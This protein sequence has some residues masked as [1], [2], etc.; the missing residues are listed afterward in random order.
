[1]EESTKTKQAV[2]FVRVNHHGV[3]DS[4]AA[5]R[6]IHEQRISGHELAERVNATVV[7]EYIERGG[8]VELGQRGTLLTMLGDLILHKDIDYVIA[9]DISRISR[10]IEDV[11]TVR[12]IIGDNGAW[13]VTTKSVEFLPEEALNREIEQAANE[14]MKRFA[15]D[16]PDAFG[17][18]LSKV[19]QIVETYIGRQGTIAI[20]RSR[21][22]RKVSAKK[23]GR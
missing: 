16:V 20:Q 22:K 7:R 4:D 5:E 3:G 6:L 13:L 9:Q 12:H 1:M 21:Q 11:F 15:P 18:L 17:E 10:K 19:R 14:V 2:L 8:A 23:G